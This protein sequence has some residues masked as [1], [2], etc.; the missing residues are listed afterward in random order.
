ML[1]HSTVLLHPPPHRLE[2]HGCSSF[3][4]TSS[5][6]Y[7]HAFISPIVKVSLH[8]TFLWSYCS[9]YFLPAV[10]TSQ[11]GY[12]IGIWRCLKFSSQCLTPSACFVTG[13]PVLVDGSSVLT[14]A[15]LHNF[16]KWRRGPGWPGDNK[17]RGVGYIVWSYEVET[18]CFLWWRKGE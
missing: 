18:M 12:L 16:K 14:V 10:C 1:C 15:E 13:L 17:G 9:I 2:G 7:T 11:L 4:S 6:A 3:P 8:L 5:S